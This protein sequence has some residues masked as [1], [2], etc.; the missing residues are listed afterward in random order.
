MPDKISREKRSEIMSHIKGKDTS[1]EV[2]VR[3]WLYHNG[4][5]YRKD[6]NKIIGSP[7]IS[8]QKYRVAIFINGC[9]WHGHENCKYFRL[10][11]SNELFWENKINRNMERDRENYARLEKENWLVIVVW[12]CDLKRDFNREMERL[13]VAIL[14][15]KSNPIIR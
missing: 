5:R 13:L 4:I 8:I 2:A 3:H 15:M 7:D 14:E 12:E 10:P 9:F 6:S 1:F 11:K